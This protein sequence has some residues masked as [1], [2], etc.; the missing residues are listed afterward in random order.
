MSGPEAGIRCGGAFMPAFP[1]FVT[2]LATRAC[3]YQRPA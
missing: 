2:L 3:S 1:T